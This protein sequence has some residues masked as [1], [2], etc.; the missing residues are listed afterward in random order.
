MIEEVLPR[1]DSGLLK[2]MLRMSEIPVG[3]VEGSGE[4]VLHLRVGSECH[5]SI[6]LIKIHGNGSNAVDISGPHSIKLKPI[7]GES[8][9]LNPSSEAV[10][11]EEHVC[12]AFWDLKSHASDSLTC[13][14][15]GDASSNILTPIEMTLGFHVHFQDRRD[16]I[17][18]IEVKKTFMA[19]MRGELISLDV[20]QR[21]VY[22]DAVYDFVLSKMEL[23]S[24]PSLLM[25]L[26]VDTDSPT[27][28]DI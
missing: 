3:I 11:R 7:D 8:M 19:S 23:I 2:R 17:R 4:P 16:L 13:V 20:D 12:S 26:E 9:E 15:S 10:D 28:E 1:P 25:F 22:G 18:E 24:M 6:G 27:G 5:I 21:F 14:S